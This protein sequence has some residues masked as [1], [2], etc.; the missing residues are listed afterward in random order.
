MTEIE[1]Q[2]VDHNVEHFEE[3]L[4]NLIEI[5][6]DEEPSGF[7]HEENENIKTNEVD[8]YKNSCSLVN[9]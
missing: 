2:D 6:G 4:E 3:N 8:V 5:E 9:L 1:N 7:D